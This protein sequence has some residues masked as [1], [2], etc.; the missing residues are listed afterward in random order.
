MNHIDHVSEK[1]SYIE[2]STYQIYNH[3]STSSIPDDF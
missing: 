1:A 3:Y 2:S